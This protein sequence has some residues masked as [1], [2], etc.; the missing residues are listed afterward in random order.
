MTQ[1][2]LISCVASATGESLRTIHCPWVQPRHRVAEDLEPED[3]RLVV[4][5]P[6]CRKSLPFP[7][8]ASDGSLPMGECLSC[9]V[10]F[11]FETDEVYAA[12]TIADRSSVDVS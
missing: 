8:L 9:D 6:F 4:D 11:P 12:G 10:Y 1:T 5:C 3:L 2:Q 7:G